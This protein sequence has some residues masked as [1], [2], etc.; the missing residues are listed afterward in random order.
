MGLVPYCLNEYTRGVFPLKVFEYLA[1]GLAVV[2]TPL[3]SVVSSPPYGVRF[4]DSDDF[5]P[6]VLEELGSFS[7]DEAAL[8][9]QRAM[10]HSWGARVADAVAL[11]HRLLETP[12]AR[13]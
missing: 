4:A 10:G 3:P 13:R 12:D 8:R 2:T 7:G 6:A 5:V 1:A 11:V 9:R